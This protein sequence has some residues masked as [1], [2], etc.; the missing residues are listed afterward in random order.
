LGYGSLHPCWCLLFCQLPNVPG[1]F[2]GIVITGFLGWTK[3]KLLHFVVQQSKWTVPSWLQFMTKV[4]IILPRTASLT[5]SAQHLTPKSVWNKTGCT[6]LNGCFFAIE[7]IQAAATRSCQ[8]NFDGKP[9]LQL[10]G[11][12]LVC[13]YCPHIIISI[14]SGKDVICKE[15]SQALVAGVMPAVF[16]QL[17]LLPPHSTSIPLG[18]MPHLMSPPLPPSTAIPLSE[19]TRAPLKAKK[20]RTLSIDL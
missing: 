12:R 3:I 2:C 13:P 19:L 16:R 10:P 15:G 9:S 7:R 20:Y 17:L 11:H 4:C 18:I 14:F 1:V 8:W 5:F 6:L